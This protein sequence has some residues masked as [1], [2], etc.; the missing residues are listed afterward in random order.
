MALPMNNEFANSELSIDALEAQVAALNLTA[1]QKTSL[2]ATLQA[3][4]LVL[5]AV[6]KITGKLGNHAHHQ[7]EITRICV[8]SVLLVFC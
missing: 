1:G 7:T 4:G 5:G 6:T 8:I 2:T 3:A